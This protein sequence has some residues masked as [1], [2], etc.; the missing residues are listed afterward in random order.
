MFA[1]IRHGETDWNLAGRLQGRSDVPLN[2]R[3]REQAMDAAARLRGMLHWS[4]VVSSPLVRA[5][6]TAQIIASALDVHFHGTLVEL[7]EQ[8]FGYAEGLPV[9]QFEG[10]WPR[11][12]EL[13]MESGADVGVRGRT[14]LERLSADNPGGHLVVVT[15][16]ALIRRTVAAIS[17]LPFEHIPPVPNGSPSLLT[18]HLGVW[19][20]ETLAEVDFATVRDA[21]GTAS[22][23]VA[24]SDALSKS[25]RGASAPL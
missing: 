25:P 10:L 4:A 21:A 15:H 24:G 22:K 14:A 12:R 1:L 3:G 6:E 7:M 18:E 9:A 16:G 11:W 23:S 20:V 8:D 13:G 2:D 19:R 17:G 5:R